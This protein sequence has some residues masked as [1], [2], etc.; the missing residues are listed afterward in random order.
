MILTSHPY[1]VN[2]SSL[3]GSVNYFHPDESLPSLPEQLPVDFL[4]GQFKGGITD[5]FA[6]YGDAAALYQAPCLA[7]GIRHAERHEQVHHPDA[8]AGEPRGFHP[9]LG[10][11]LRHLLQPEDLAERIRSIACVSLAVVC[12]HDLHAQALLG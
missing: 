10:N 8:A 7:V 5:F 4:E 2:A 11:V 9:R 3:S 12:L 1:S 6:L